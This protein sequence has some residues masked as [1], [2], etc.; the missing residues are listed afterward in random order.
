M[1]TDFSACKTGMDRMNVT[2][3]SVSV[4]RCVCLRSSVLPIYLLLLQVPLFT[5][6]ATYLQPNYV[7]TEERSNSIVNDR[8]TS[9]QENNRSREGPKLRLVG[10]GTHDQIGP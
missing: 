6:I 1:G 9:T 8:E 10:R 2:S 5:L 7:A 3:E 4:F